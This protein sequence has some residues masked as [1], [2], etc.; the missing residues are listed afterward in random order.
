MFGDV[1]RIVLM[2]AVSIASVQAADTTFNPPQIPERPAAFAL[3][4]AGN[5]YIAGQFTGTLD[6]NPGTGDVSRTSVGS[7]DVFLIRLNADGGFAWAHSLGTS[8]GESVFSVALNGSFVY[9][10]GSLGGANPMLDNTTTLTNPAGPF[11]A[12]FDATTGAAKGDFNGDGIAD[13]AGLTQPAKMASIG[14]NLY[15]AGA[16]ANIA[17]IVK[18][19]ASTGV[20]DAAFT[21][22]FTGG[23]TV[24]VG[25][26][27]G[28]GTNVYL[29]GNFAGTA[30]IGAGPGT[31]NS[32]GGND[33]FV[34]A[35]KLSDATPQTGFATTG[36]I[37]FGGNGNEQFSSLS[38][39]D[40]KLFVGG[41]L[42]STNAGFGAAGSI[43]R[44][45]AEADGIVLA[46]NSAGTPVGSFDGDGV[47]LIS[48]PADGDVAR[49]KLSAELG[50]GVATPGI[51]VQ[52]T[53][54][55]QVG[56]PPQVV[57]ADFD[58]SG[59]KRLAFG[60]NGEILFDGSSTDTGVDV[61]RVNGRTAFAA[62]GNSSSEPYIKTN[63]LIPRALTGGNVN[64][65]ASFASDTGAPTFP[66]F[67]DVFP[68][69]D[70]VAGGRTVSFF[71]NGFANGLNVKIAAADATGVN[72]AS[73]TK[74]TATI[75]PGTTG[76]KT[77]AITLAN[78][79]TITVPLAFAYGNKAQATGSVIRGPVKD[80][81]VDADGNTYFCGTFS[82]TVD[83][84]PSANSDMQRSA[85]SASTAF[86]TR[87]NA[88][89]SYGWTSTFVGLGNTT[90][91]ALAVKGDRVFAVGD[92][93]FANL[94]GEAASNG[95]IN[96]LGNALCK[97]QGDGVILVLNRVDGT[98]ATSVSGDGIVL[99][100]GSTDSSFGSTDALHSIA[101]S[102]TS[103]A[104]AIGGRIAAN[105][106]GFDGVGAI[107]AGGLF[108][109]VDTDVNVTQNTLLAYPQ[110]A[111]VSSTRSVLVDYSPDGTKL[112][113]A[114]FAG[115]QLDM[116]QFSG[117]FGTVLN[118]FG[119]AG[120]KSTTFG[121]NLQGAN[122]DESNTDIAIAATKA[123][124][125]A[126][127][128]ILDSSSG[129]AATP[130]EIAPKPGQS[131]SRSVDNVFANYSLQDL[132][133]A[134]AARGDVTLTSGSTV[135][136]LD[137]QTV[138]QFDTNILIVKGTLA[139]LLG[140]GSSLQVIKGDGGG[141]E[142]I[143]AFIAAPGGV[144]IVGESSSPSTVVRKGTETATPGL[145]KGFVFDVANGGA[146]PGI[147]PDITSA[148][149]QEIESG[150][151]FAYTITAT[152]TAVITFN[153]TEPFDV[154]PNGKIQQLKARG[155]DALSVSFSG[156]TL[157]VKCLVPGAVFTIG[158]SATNAIDTD[159]SAVTFTTKANPKAPV[160][161]FGS[162]FDSGGTVD[163][164]VGKVTVPYTVTGDQPLTITPQV[165]NGL[166]DATFNLI[167][168][169][170]GTQPAV[171]DYTFSGFSFFTVTAVNE[172]GAD[173]K[174][175]LLEVKDTDTDSDG[176]PDRFDDDDDGDGVPDDIENELLTDPK[177]AG[178][179]P[180]IEIGSVV[181]GSAKGLIIQFKY[182]NSDVPAVSIS[183]QIVEDKIL[184]L[185]RAAPMPTPG[186][187]IYELG[188][189]VRMF[190]IDGKGKGVSGN[191]KASVKVKSVKG[192]LTT[193][194]SVSIKNSDI[195]GKLSD[196]GF[197]N[198]TTKKEMLTVKSFVAY[199]GKAINRTMTLEYTA[200]QG[201]TGSA[202]LKK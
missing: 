45:G 71:G 16:N 126:T 190:T 134:I 116:K 173:Y 146:P 13:V 189:V 98:A 47:L 166:T 41:I 115:T 36:L 180:S 132:V 99:V 194:I 43:T 172:F 195:K 165:S 12:A 104:L 97:G 39:T 96:G 152:G 160:I 112:T 144:K 7:S 119:T 92:L 68:R 59:A 184:N 136:D 49:V 187:L 75:P 30:M 90:L 103:N 191:D 34:A 23:T 17:T 86:V 122:F 22:T 170:D 79:C 148:T 70:D 163:V 147:P 185:S 26:I 174:F 159:R 141:R 28:D 78:G 196:E 83:F 54:R 113:G 109:N 200:K 161:T 156:S 21:P 137:A 158:L 85:N 169:G 186:T 128:Q 182:V 84:D 14:A 31:V 124:G 130:L 177:S 94:Q 6:L 63:N 118:S 25:D 188:G 91:N 117:N 4:A 181:P 29:A 15:F 150:V 27:A 33:G 133:V 46:F 64:V 58:A 157:R 32:V 61:V 52:S 19:D 82:G 44:A 142:D 102:P 55:T 145:F 193:S 5:Q 8:G 24:A 48:P 57:V 139:N 66:H 80:G 127:L 72:V 50:A 81:S 74:F 56:F 164:N 42:N 9:V 18:F 2:L 60:I 178:S 65:V 168:G 11:I 183:D 151:E 120:V 114:V 87:I 149:T 105:N 53:F 175:V 129:T 171:I 198:R 155:I 111:P 38:A 143:S 67:I 89:G 162:P 121:A 202:K 37:T 199:N 77:V 153:V 76:D 10:A 123:D 62:F 93:Q 131:G 154:V 73:G 125:T 20:L 100:G 167:D 3:D 201:K 1:C 88:N 110:T 35:F 69:A 107:T 101:A 51:A 197:T 40:G 138:D 95:G 108:F 176:T 106:A 179:K 192:E 140:L 135:V